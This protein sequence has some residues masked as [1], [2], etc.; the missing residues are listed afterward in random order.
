MYRDRGFMFIAVVAQYAE[1]EIAAFGLTHAVIDDPAAELITQAYAPP[2]S[3][4]LPAMTVLNRRM[5]VVAWHWTMI[6]EMFLLD[7]LDEPYPEVD[8]LPPNTLP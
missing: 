1:E 6:D 2:A 4:F 5:E 7:L 3:P 8:Y